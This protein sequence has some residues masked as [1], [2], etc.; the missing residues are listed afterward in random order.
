MI[1]AVA[2]ETV[3]AIGMVERADDPDAILG[4]LFRSHYRQLVGLARLL[5]DDDGQAEETVQEAFARTY[6]SWSRLRDHDDPLPYVRRAVVNQAR[7]RLRRRRTVRT[8]RIEPMLDAA[9]P[10]VG[11]LAAERR[12]EIVAAVGALP[13]RQRECVALRYYLDASV[14]DTA[15]T[16]GI[17]E[18]AVKQHTHRALDALSRALDHGDE[19]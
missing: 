18:G 15:L 7:G 5:V 2:R 19:R 14:S 12:S 1:L 6:A 8:T 11:I 10:E 17:S 16:L 4:A 3:G 13:R 9:S